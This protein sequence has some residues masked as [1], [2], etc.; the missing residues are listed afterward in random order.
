[1]LRQVDE[2]AEKMAS[3]IAVTK[4]IAYAAEDDIKKTESKKIEQDLLIDQL[5]EQVCAHAKRLFFNFSE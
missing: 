3:E 2:Y 4:R 1:M 5:N